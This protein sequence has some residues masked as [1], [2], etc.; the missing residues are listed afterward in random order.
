LL[1][2]SLRQP[3]GALPPLSFG[4]PSAF[5]EPDGRPLRRHFEPAGVAVLFQRAGRRG[6]RQM[7]R[8]TR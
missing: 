7:E 2:S 6:E 1:Q 8:A 4:A 5:A 3:Y